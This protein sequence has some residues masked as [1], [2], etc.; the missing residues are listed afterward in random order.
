MNY[1]TFVCIGHMREPPICRIAFMSRKHALTNAQASRHTNDQP[2]P[3]VN[4]YVNIFELANNK[5]HD[6]SLRIPYLNCQHKAR[7]CVCVAILLAA[8]FLYFL[9]VRS[10]H[11]ACKVDLFLVNICS[12]RYHKNLNLKLTSEFMSNNLINSMSIDASPPQHH[13]PHICI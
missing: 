7:L 10:R 1:T 9:V 3:Q 5:N 11:D 6:P 2:R 13:T 8:W 4:A 12:Y